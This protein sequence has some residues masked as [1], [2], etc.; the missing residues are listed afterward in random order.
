MIPKGVIPSCQKIHMSVPVNTKP[1]KKGNLRE[2]LNNLASCSKSPTLSQLLPDVEMIEMRDRIPD[3]FM[4]W[5]KGRNNVKVIT[6]II[7]FIYLIH[8]QVKL[9]SMW[10]K[11][12]KYHFRNDWK[13]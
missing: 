2:L 6:I 3:T 13:R 11:M 1:G 8:L 4:I 9:T 12:T 10:K 5:D 7:D